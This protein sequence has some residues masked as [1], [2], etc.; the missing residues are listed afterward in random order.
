MDYLL[1]TIQVIAEWF[2]FEIS[3]YIP[4]YLQVVDHAKCQNKMYN[5]Y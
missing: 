2:S 4:T 3:A 5:N 1:L